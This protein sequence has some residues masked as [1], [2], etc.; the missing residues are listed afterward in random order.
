MVLRIAQWYSAVI[1]F[2]I[3]GLGVRACFDGPLIHK[4]GLPMNQ[5]LQAESGS[6][7]L[8]VRI[9]SQDDVSLVFQYAFYNNAQRNAYL[10][11]KLYRGF[12]E[13]GK[14]RTERNLVYIEIDSTQATIGKKVIPVPDDLDVEKPIIPCVTLVRP[15]EK[16][17]ETVSV[18]LPLKAWTPYL[19]PKGD[20]ARES[21]AK[22]PIWFE[23][24]FF[25]TTKEG[26]AL[27]KTVQT[28]DGPALYF[29]PFSASSQS[30]LRAGPILE[31]V[32]VI[33]PE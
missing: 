19:R 28:T 31:A 24:G 11:N 23:I 5:M 20:R 13:Q 21:A 7:K 22:V 27:A 4:Q 17:E 1:V 14:Y 25:S 26:D 6:H 9:I 2:A 29:Y 8:E 33:I 30:I 32:P 18:P 16:F 3:T 15:G 10:F 12:D